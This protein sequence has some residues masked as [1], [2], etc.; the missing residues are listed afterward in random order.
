MAG[1]PIPGPLLFSEN[2]EYYLSQEMSKLRHEKTEQ[3]TQIFTVKTHEK[4]VYIS[5]FYLSFTS[6]IISFRSETYQSNMK[7][8]AEMFPYSFHSDETESAPRL[9]NSLHRIQN[10]VEV[11]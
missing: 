9:Q 11:T 10:E 5:E 8:K 7:G 3:M 6:D 1:F 4:S 2:Q